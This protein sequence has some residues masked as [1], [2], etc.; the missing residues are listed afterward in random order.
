M[1][2][3]T[4]TNVKYMQYNSSG[5]MNFIK[6]IVITTLC[7]LCCACANKA[8]PS[9]A[10]I[11]SAPVP[12]PRIAKSEQANRIANKLLIVIPS[13]YDLSDYTLDM[14]LVDNANTTT[15]MADI[16]ALDMARTIEMQNYV[17]T[18]FDAARFAS[19]QLKYAGYNT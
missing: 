18:G 19:T 12:V 15:E 2:Y 4:Y 8:Q 13:K 7:S 16:I 1:K 9:A 5:S 17:E 3:Q 11:A 14:S 10:A 6:I